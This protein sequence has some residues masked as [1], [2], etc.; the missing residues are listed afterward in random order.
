[1]LAKA[2]SASGPSSPSRWAASRTTRSEPTR[3]PTNASTCWLDASIQCTSSASTSTGFLVAASASRSSAAMATEYRS[4]GESEALPNA[5][6]SA[7]RRCRESRIARLSTGR[8]IWW[9]PANG[10]PNSAAVPTACSIWN[11]SPAVAVAHSSSAD[12]ADPRLASD[13]QR[14]T[15]S[16]CLIEQAGDQASLRVSPAERDVVGQLSSVTSGLSRP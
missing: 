16:G 14:R 9:S 15:P 13:Y 1:M 11:L 2:G 4:G 8:T 3:R 6:S 12:F 10:K 7:S 5:T